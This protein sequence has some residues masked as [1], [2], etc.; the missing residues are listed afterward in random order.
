MEEG[1]FEPPH[2]PKGSKKEEHIWGKSKDPKKP[3]DLAFIK[4]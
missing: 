4:E 2:D 3:T 1:R